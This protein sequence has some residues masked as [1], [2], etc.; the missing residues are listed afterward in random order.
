[1]DAAPRPETTVFAAGGSAQG[2]GCWR[3]VLEPSSSIR[4]TQSTTATDNSPWCAQLFVIQ[5]LQAFLDW[6]SFLSLVYSVLL[7]TNL[8]I[9]EPGFM[10]WSRWRMCG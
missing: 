7:M 4:D 6:F 5:E 10:L 8:S 9:N 3:S 1:M 2:P